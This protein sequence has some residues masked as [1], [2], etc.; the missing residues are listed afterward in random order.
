M[1]AERIC[2]ALETVPERGPRAVFAATR[3]RA[4]GGTSLAL[5][6]RAWMAECR[7][8]RAVEGPAKVLDPGFGERIASHPA[9]R[10]WPLLVITNEAARAARSATNF[11]WTTFTRFEPAADISASRRELVRNH[12]A[13]TAPVVIDARLAAGFPD[14]LFCSPEISQ[15]VDERWLEYFPDR[16]V[17]MGDSGRG[18]LD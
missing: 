3:A 10:D 11:L 15:R 4:L 17:E 1:L 13:F 5:V 9:F 2:S 16:K 12:V 14:E 8:V 18:H 6:M 7:A